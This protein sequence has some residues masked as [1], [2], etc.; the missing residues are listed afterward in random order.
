[1]AAPRICS[2]LGCGKRS[3]AC[4]LCSSHFRR[5]TR[6]GEALTYSVHQ[7]TAKRVCSVADCGRPVDGRGWCQAHYLRWYFTGD[8]SADKPLKRVAR[9]G[10]PECFLRQ[11]IATDDDECLL[12]PYTKSTYGYGEIVPGGRGHKKE[13]VHRLVCEA[14][15]GP[16]PKGKNDAAHSCGNRLCCNP[17]HLRWASR[18]ENMA[19][20][21][22]HG[23]IPRGEK[24]GSARLT[25]KQV[26]E[27]RAQ[28]GHKTAPEVAAQYGVTSG[29][30]QAIF[31]R[32]SWSWLE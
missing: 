31:Q 14:V 24:S 7:P 10:E 19:D 30:I 12:W 23:T 18:L 15:H 16:P 1:M 4:G 13:S 8:V 27:I 21:R 25:E 28:F 17:R 5:A 6:R 20:S 3:R 9:H 32:K 11:A 2:V 26:L 29:A 22:R